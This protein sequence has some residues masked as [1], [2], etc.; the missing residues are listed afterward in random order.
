MHSK[1]FFDLLDAADVR[2]VLE[3]EVVVALLT[4]GTV[5]KDTLLVHLRKLRLVNE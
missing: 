2:L 4:Y 3:D 1:L 5:T